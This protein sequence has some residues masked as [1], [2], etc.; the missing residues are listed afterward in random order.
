MQILNNVIRSTTVGQLP[1]VE[2]LLGSIPTSAT[3]Q[4][5]ITKRRQA[6]AAILEGQ[7]PR[8]LVI[9][10]PCSIHDP[11]QGLEY[12]RKLAAVQADYA[13]Q[14]LIVMRTYFEKPRTRTGW[15]GLIVD[16][17]LDG[18]HNMAKGLSVARTFLR[19]VTDLGL[20]T[21]TEFLDTTV[22]PYISDLICW[23]AIGARTTESQIHRQMA[24]ALPCPIGF[25]NGTDGNVSIAIDAIHAAQAEH[26]MSVAGTQGAPALVMTHGNPHGHVILRGGKVPNYHSDDVVSVS[27]QLEESGLNPRLIIDCSHGNSLKKAHNQLGVAQDIAQQLLAGETC[28]A[29]VMCESFLKQGNQS[30]GNGD[31]EPGLSITDECLSWDNTVKLLD[32]LAE[33]M[34]GVLSQRY[35][36][37]A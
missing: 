21:A 20:A 25:K 15:K 33:A 11:K 27:K 13:D 35:S 6:I 12:A 31:L 5:L 10:G 7:D 19:D 18:A 32:T 8:L 14:L 29:G 16:P 26:V 34:N 30:L 4:A 1:F 9:V 36:T 3:Q 2:T 37:V 28:I 17:D 24:S 23:G 22:Y